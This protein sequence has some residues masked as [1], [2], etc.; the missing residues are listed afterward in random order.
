MSIYIHTH[1]LSTARSPFLILKQDHTR[2]SVHGADVKSS[3][4]CTE[5]RQHRPRERQ[6]AERRGLH[7]AVP[8]GAAK[9]VAAHPRAPRRVEQVRG[10]QRA[11]GGRLRVVP[12]ESLRMQ[13]RRRRRLLAGALGLGGGSETV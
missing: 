2:G 7:A 5:Q 8:L 1:T 13:H 6:A 11:R 3:S 10:G 4:A 12:R 9:E